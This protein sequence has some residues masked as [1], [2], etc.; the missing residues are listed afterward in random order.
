MATWESSSEN[1][2]VHARVESSDPFEIAGQ[3]VVSCIAQ[4]SFY[5]PYPNTKT[6]AHWACIVPKEYESSTKRDLSETLGAYMEHIDANEDDSED[7]E[8]E[9]EVTI[10]EVTEE[11]RGR[12]DFLG[13][14]VMEL[15]ENTVLNCVLVAGGRRLMLTTT[16]QPNESNPFQSTLFIPS[17]TDR[18]GH[19]TALITEY[20]HSGVLAQG[21]TAFERRPKIKER[22]EERREREK[23]E[24]LSI[25]QQALWEVY[26]QAV[27]DTVIFPLSGE[28]NRNYVHLVARYVSERLAS[29][30]SIR[31]N[32]IS[33]AQVHQF[34]AEGLPRFRTEDK[35]VQ[36]TGRDDERSPINGS[37]LYQL[38]ERF[39]S[40]LSQMKTSITEITELPSDELV[41]AAY[42][43]LAWQEQIFLI[44][45]GL[46]KGDVPHLQGEF[47]YDPVTRQFL[48]RLAY[49]RVIFGSEDKPLPDTFETMDQEESRERSTKGKGELNEHFFIVRRTPRSVV[50]RKQ[51]TIVDPDTGN[52]VHI[53]S[54]YTIP[55]SIDPQQLLGDELSPN[56]LIQ[57][58]NSFNY[59]LFKGDSLS[60]FH[61]LANE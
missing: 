36:N 28:I 7:I 41:F 43:Y 46:P 51:K 27:N 26:L 31:R 42:L 3:S 47:T 39:H 15:E 29:G 49:T 50:M 58:L 56:I 23:Q 17:R 59:Q 16:Y 55:L 11:L 4:M 5:N 54:Q 25:S 13:Y 38:F 24:R 19:E 8:R 9:I 37:F 32:D 10:N 12:D 52:P 14:R 48:G 53:F 6:V 34:L 18:G 40:H 2:N 21:T 45:H 33:L 1:E 44:A 22:L 60:S 30:I 57:L 35:E 20:D 61:P